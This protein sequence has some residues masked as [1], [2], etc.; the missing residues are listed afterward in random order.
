MT[1]H[2][3]QLLHKPRSPKLWEESWDPTEIDFVNNDMEAMPDTNVVNLNRKLVQFMIREFLNPMERRVIEAFM[4][5]QTHKSIG[6]TEKH[7]RYHVEKALTRMRK[8]LI[9]TPHQVRLKLDFN[10]RNYDKHH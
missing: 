2:R 8:K 6:V 1:E 3:K 5:G 4:E 10:R 9:D 7:W